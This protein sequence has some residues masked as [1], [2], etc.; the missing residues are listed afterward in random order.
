MG[1]KIEFTGDLGSDEYP[2]TGFFFE[3]FTSNELSSSYD[4]GVLLQLDSPYLLREI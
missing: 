4:D 1:D 2:I 3:K